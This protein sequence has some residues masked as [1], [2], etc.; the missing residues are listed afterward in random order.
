MNKL[1]LIILFAMLSLPVNAMSFNTAKPVLREIYLTLNQEL[2][3]TTT[4]YSNCPIKYLSSSSSVYWKLDCDYSAKVNRRRANR[5]EVEHI[6]PAWEFGHKL[7]CWKEG[8][9]NNCRTSD[10]RFRE[11]EGDLHNLFPSIGEINMVR[12]YFKF[13]DQDIGNNV[14]GDLTVNKQRR[15][16]NP[17]KYA[18]GQVARAYLYMIHTY[19]VYVS[20]PQYAMFW[21]WN[22]AYKPS[23]LECLR[24]VLIKQSQGNDNKFITEKCSN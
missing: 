24:N 13:T 23:K 2:G 17:P 21:K 12:S 6:M 11:M 10:H 16:V 19:K 4:I 15:L 5:I 22:N 1:F 20:K 7:D 18:R 9:R 3:K 8:G 14:Y